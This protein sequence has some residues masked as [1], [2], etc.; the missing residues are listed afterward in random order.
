ML[1]EK[2]EKDDPLSSSV[3]S[4]MFGRAKFSKG[5]VYYANSDV[6]SRHHLGYVSDS[7]VGEGLYSVNSYCQLK[8]RCRTLT[9]VAFTVFE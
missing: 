9:S 6:C 5:A 2:S 7:S 4:C 8:S 1:V 3:D